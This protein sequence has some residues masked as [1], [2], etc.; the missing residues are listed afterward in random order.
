[1]T[2]VAFASGFQTIRQFNGAFKQLYGRAPRDFRRAAGRNENSTSACFQ[3]KLA[4]RPPLDWVS[5]LKFLQPR[6][7]SGIECIYGFTYRRFVAMQNEYGILEVRHCPERHCLKLAVPSQLWC[8]AR[9]F[10]E[11]A[12]RMFDLDTDPMAVSVHLRTDP[13]LADLI[14]SDSSIR[15]PGGWEP[16][17]D[18]I[19][20]ILGQQVSVSGATTLC[21]RL[22]RQLGK[23]LGD[24]E[25]G[26]TFPTPTV[27]ANADITSIGIPKSRANAIQEFSRA[28]ASR[29]I[30]FDG[31]VS[32]T[33]FLG[34]AESL[35]WNR[36]LD[37]KLHRD[38]VFEGTECVSLRR[39]RH[40]KGTFSRATEPYV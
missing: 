10:V 9:S 31:A 24:E 2:K 39:P 30:D 4:Y 26:W 3:M 38:A 12:R 13:V 32:L 29:Y 34:R 6:L 11:Q 23:R 1:M 25:L 33:E 18:S 22:I 20:I 14:G 37:R 35:R 8:Y 17:A 27:L 15:L 28:V 40:P 16:F 5:L 19:R 36:S 7:L 21:S